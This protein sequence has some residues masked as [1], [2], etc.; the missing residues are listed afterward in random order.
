MDEPDFLADFP[1]LKRQLVVLDA[2]QVGNTIS[3]RWP[4]GQLKRDED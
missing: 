1:I 4:C 2:D 3:R